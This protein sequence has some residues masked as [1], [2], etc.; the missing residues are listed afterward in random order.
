MEAINLTKEQV[1]QITNLRLIKVSC[2]DIAN[3]LDISRSIISNIDRA[4]SGIK[5]SYDRLNNHNKSIIDSLTKEV[6]PQ[7]YEVKI[8]FGLITLKINP[9]K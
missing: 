2:R 3:Q 7:K 6:N 1:L 8:L 5:S 4:F 9:T